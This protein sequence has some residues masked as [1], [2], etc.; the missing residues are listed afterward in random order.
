MRKVVQGRTYEVREAVEEYLNEELPKFDLKVANDVGQLGFRIVSKEIRLV[1]GY[2][3]RWGT[4]KPYLVVGIVRLDDKYYACFYDLID[5]EQY[6]EEVKLDVNGNITETH[7]ILDQ[8]EW[9]VVA[10]YFNLNNFVTS[11]RIINWIMSYRSTD[12][13][14]FVRLVRTLE[15]YQRAKKEHPDLTEAEVYQ[16]AIKPSDLLQKSLNGGSMHSRPLDYK[17]CEKLITDYFK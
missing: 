16:K 6:V 10:N 5:H 17:T 15:W 8:T 7:F 14:G 13:E 11:A 2:D 1:P 4:P 12:P 9:L 3:K